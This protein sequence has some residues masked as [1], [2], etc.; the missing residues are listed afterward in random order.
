MEQKVAVVTGG[1]SG[2]GKGIADRLAKDG[3]SLVISDVNENFLET[4]ENEFKSK[5]QKVAVFKGDVS[6]KKD[7]EALANLAVEKFGRI[8]VWVN[9]A[10]IE[11][12]VPFADITTESFCY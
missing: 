5:G 7:Q 8:D 12:V 9:N 10:G 6:L 11:S 3:F 2:L 1:A 4:A